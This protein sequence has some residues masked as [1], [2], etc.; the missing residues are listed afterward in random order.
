MKKGGGGFSFGTKP[1][2]RSSV[3][4]RER[5]LV[6]C[7][8]NSYAECRHMTI[9]CFLARFRSRALMRLKIFQILLEKLQQEVFT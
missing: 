4:Q 7:V 3:Q 1:A 5:P 2:R 8:S 9:S 6:C